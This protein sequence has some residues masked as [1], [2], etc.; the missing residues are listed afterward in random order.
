M[1]NLFNLNGFLNIFC[2]SSFTDF[3]PNLF[4]CNSFKLE[5]YNVILAIAE[6]RN[7]ILKLEDSKAFLFNKKKLNLGK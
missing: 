5:I 6:K 7:A 3:F 1:K 4:Y 2:R